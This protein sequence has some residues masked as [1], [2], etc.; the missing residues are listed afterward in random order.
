MA[1]DETYECKIME[2]LFLSRVIDL[3][4]ILGRQAYCTMLRKIKWNVH[5]TDNKYMQDM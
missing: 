5:Y 1:T 2:N 4:T 3:K